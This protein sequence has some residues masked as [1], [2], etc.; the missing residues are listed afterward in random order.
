[1]L[2]HQ[3]FL[4][5]FPSGSR[6]TATIALVAAILFWAGNSVAGRMSIGVVPP[7]ALAFWRWFFAFVCLLLITWRQLREHRNSIWRYRYRLLMLAVLSITTFNTLLYLAAQSTQ[8]V[9][10]AL[11]QTSLPLVTI[12][13]SIFLLNE[14][15]RVRQV[16]GLLIILSGL[17]YVISRGEWQQLLMLQSQQGDLY[18]L[19]AVTCWGL[20]SVLYKR[21]AIPLSGIVI[22]TVLVGIGMPVLLPFYLWEYSVVGGFAVTFQSVALLVYVTVFA[23]ILSYLA[24]NNGV[25]VLGSSSASLFNSLMPVFVALLAFLFLGESL[26]SYHFVGGGLILMGLW[27]ALHRRHA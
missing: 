17:L 16:V 13:L 15:P 26:H 6:A 4:R 3:Y 14:I 12:L 22:L 10:I 21:F 18:M 24:W 5:F 27:L 23:S 7:V 11:I 8:A 25:R 19:V 2:S 1:M 20:Y 9:N